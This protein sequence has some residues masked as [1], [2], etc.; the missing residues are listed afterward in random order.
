MKHIHIKC[1]CSC[2]VHCRD[3]AHRVGEGSVD[4]DLWSRT[5]SREPLRT[6]RRV[7]SF[8]WMVCPF[9]PTFNC[10]FASFVLTLSSPFLSPISAL[11]ASFFG[12]GIGLELTHPAPTDIRCYAP[13]PQLASTRIL[14]NLMVIG[15]NFTTQSPDIFAMNDE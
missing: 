5:E 10:H 8:E 6:R 14:A 2:S 11:I 1:L 4:G 3:F 15:N 7:L 9:S 12:T 13:Y